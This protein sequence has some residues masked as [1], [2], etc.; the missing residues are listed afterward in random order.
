MRPMPDRPWMSQPSPIVDVAAC[1]TRYQEET[2]AGESTALCSCGTFAIGICSDCHRLVCGECSGMHV[3]QRTCTACLEAIRQAE[4]EKQRRAEERAI[5]ERV[6]W[7]N[8]PL[9]LSRPQAFDILFIREADQREINSAVGCLESIE[10]PEFRELAIACLEAAGRPLKEETLHD[11][12]RGFLARLRSYRVWWFFAPR[13]RGI[14]YVGITPEG[15]WMEWTESSGD[16]DWGVRRYAD[17]TTS[18]VRDL[19]SDASRGGGGRS[20]GNSFFQRP[21]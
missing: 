5:A 7:E 1:G 16:R 13:T 10:E 18:A 12:S 20:A 15:R 2:T 6:T 3:S 4:A 9:T 8:E 14:Q 11:R 17:L 19:I 21:F